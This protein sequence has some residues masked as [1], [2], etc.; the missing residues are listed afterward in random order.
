MNTLTNFTAQV[1]ILIIE[2]KQKL[3]F[4]F[5]SND[6]IFNK[7]AE[8]IITNNGNGRREELQYCKFYKYQLLKS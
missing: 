6:N 7:N 1:D 8:D 4:L 5:R 2:R 3:K